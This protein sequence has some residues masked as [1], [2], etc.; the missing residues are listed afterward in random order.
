M[1][2]TLNLESTFSETIASHLRL[3]RHLE[4]QQEKLQAIAKRMTQALLDGNKILWCG[5]GGSAADAQ[6]LSAELVGRFRRER[7]GMASMA[8]TDNPAAILGIANDYGFNE[9]FIRQVEALCQPGD[10]FV[11]LSTTSNSR[12]VT[13]AAQRAKELGA[14][15]IAITGD[16]GGKFGSAADIWL[17]L[18]SREAARVQEAYMVCGH[19][20]CDWI[21]TGMWLNQAVEG[22]RNAG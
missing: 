5:N 9:V 19:I 17:R 21:E 7:A 1:I 4:F 16:H 13:T 20:L 3:I 22:Q 10:I 8:L 11:G 12:N 2:A 6:H 18:P 15:T 14:F